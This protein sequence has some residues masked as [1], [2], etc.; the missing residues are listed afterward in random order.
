MPSLLLAV[1]NT[2]ILPGLAVTVAAAVAVLATLLV[3]GLSRPAVARA[4]MIAGG[5]PIA[6]LP[7]VAASAF[8]A[9][10]SG[11]LLGGLPDFGPSGQVQAVTASLWQL[12][13]LA[14]A[15]FA[16]ACVVGLALGLVRAG[17]GDAGEAASARRGVVLLLLPLAGLLLTAL[18][19]Q[20]VAKGTRVGAIALSS[21]G[22]DAS[23]RERGE[24]AL[25]A[26]GFSMSKSGDLGR[27]ARY[28]S[29]T[30]LVGTF[31]GAFVATVLLGL[32]LPGFILAW[33]ARFDTPFRV[34]AAAVWLI[35]AVFGLLASLGMLS[36][37]RF[38]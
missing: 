20:S 12:Q 9:A 29:R 28:L 21:M 4:G 2:E 7:P 22:D 30:T 1:T 13:S 5:L 3:A 11:G 32:A 19:T 37:F 14:W 16:L 25:E 24:A 34:G 26:E 36:A 6:L 10:K 27:L 35:G 31:G 15:A 33:R 23:A 17:G 8:V 18:V 38:S